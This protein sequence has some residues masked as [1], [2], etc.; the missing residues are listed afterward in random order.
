MPDE[1]SLSED[2]RFRSPEACDGALRAV[3]PCARTGLF[4]A[5]WMTDALDFYGKPMAYGTN[6]NRVGMGCSAVPI[7]SG[8]TILIQ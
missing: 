2:P 7:T 5:S 1:H 6:K 3:S 4:T 8:M